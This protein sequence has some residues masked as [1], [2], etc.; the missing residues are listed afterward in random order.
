[1]RRG[2][3]WLLL[4][5]LASP[6]IAQSA[7]SPPEDA[8]S[9]ASARPA[10]VSLQPVIV[11]AQRRQTVL[12]T[13]PLSV[14]VVDLHSIETNGTAQLS[15]LV[16]TVPGVTVPNGFSNQPQAVGIRGM[17]VS[18]PAMS[19][20]V[21]IYVD[22][23]PLIRGYATALWDLP[24]IARIEVLR[25][26]QGTLYG[27]NLT[28]G[29]VRVISI[30]PSRAP[31]AWGSV[32]LGNYRN[33]EVHAYVNGPIGD[34][35][36]SGSFALSSRGNDG[37]G[38]NAS[39]GER[40]NKL[41]ATQFRAKLR[42][43]QPSGTDAVLAVDGLLD[44]SD[45]NTGNF[46]L[47]DPQSAPRVTFVTATP[48]PFKRLSGGL[49]LKVTHPLGDGIDLHS[50]TGYRAYW[51]D[52]TIADI[53]G[54]AA[55]RYLLSQ[56]VEQK[57]FSQEV[58]LQS[59]QDRLAWTAGLMLVSD[60][61]DFDRIV[62]QIPPPPKSRADTEGQTHLETTDVGVYGQSHYQ[63]TDEIGL[64][65]GLRAY[66]TTQTGDN[67]FWRLDAQQQRTQEVYH[68]T[69]LSTASQGLLPRLGVDWQRNPDHFLYA[70]FAMGQK[71][72]GFNRATASERAST[73]AARPEK[74]STWELGSKWRLA[75]GRLTA[76]VALFLN[77]Y[78]EYLAA[79]QNT[80]INGVQVPDQ[81]LVNAGRA[82]TY[83][84]D[85]DLAAKLAAQTELALS[86]ELLR[87]R[88][89]EFA[90][91]TGAAISNYVGNE[92]PYASHL[93]LSAR[94]GHVQPLPDGSSLEFSATLQHLSRQ[95]ADV[96]NTAAI[97]I[98]PQTYVNFATNW[99]SPE[100]RW[101]FSVRVR[102]ATNRTHVVL[103]TMIPS[104]DV[105][106]ANYNAPRTWLATLRRDF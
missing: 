42:L 23:V 71:F 96:Q 28:A 19:Q 102:N 31:V 58:Q 83:G 7:P 4:A 95:Y 29:A 99:S 21:G 27:Q 24:D 82:K 101:S 66:R 39:T 41:D 14:G 74:V 56:K 93:S 67:Q 77:R 90:N 51:D 81:V 12:G 2:I 18:V 36:L 20:A 60:R 35:P 65:A 40:V 104:V 69:D 47:N 94:F 45:T 53:G 63:W 80:V 88:I 8:A 72:G 22:D 46:P 11:T 37:F 15:D 5:Y 62:D 30:D 33:A 76:D 91:P 17:G 57:A 68:A 105:D 48:G 92:L 52:P 75:G 78:G 61:F 84:A 44:R 16:G 1:M 34:G 87:S 9:A 25:G 49:Q 86:V 6:A 97:A 43:K 79:L 55:L 3:A 103:R 59:R 10:V 89:L 85:I 26:P 98:G 106:A 64:T 50:I 70:S 38:Y 73:Y 100:H 13:T 32:S 54:K